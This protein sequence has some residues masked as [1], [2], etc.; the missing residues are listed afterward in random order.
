MRGLTGK[1]LSLIVLL[2]SLSYGSMMAQQQNTKKEKE[3]GSGDE[4]NLSLDSVVVSAWKNRS[5]LQT[6]RGGYEW[7]MGIMHILPKF[8][9]NADPIRH[10]QV[11][12]G[13]QTNGEYAG[14][15]HVEGCDNQHNT[16]SINGVPLYNV[17]HILGFF[18]TFNPTHYTLMSLSK[19]PQDAA[20]DN[21]LGATLDM[22]LSDQLSDT[23]S[24][25]ADVGLI[26]S[27][28]TV[29]LPLGKET[30]LRLSARTSYINLLYSRW[31]RSD[32]EELKYSFYDVNASVLHKFDSKNKILLDFYTGGDNGRVFISDYLSTV[33]EHWGNTAGSLQWLHNG[34]DDFSMRHILYC[35]HYY[36]KLSLDMNAF[37]FRMPSNI[38]DLGYKGKIMWRG[39]TTGLDVIQH[40]LM[41]QHANVI[42]DYHAEVLDP[43]AQWGGEYSLYADY[44]RKLTDRLIFNTGLR[45]TIFHSNFDTYHS[46]A[47]NIGAVYN[48]DKWKISLSYAMRS[49]Y[50]FQTG[51]SSLG[52]P[53]ESWTMAGSDDIIP[54]LGHGFTAS[55]SINIAGGR[56]QL[57]L[58]AYYR[59]LDGQVEYQGTFYDFIVSDY[60]LNKHLLHGRGRNFGVSLMLTKRTGRLTGWMSYSFGRALRT[61]DNKDFD[62]TYPASH[63]RIH[64]L[65]LLASYKLSRRFNLGATFVLASGTPFTAPKY[66]YI[67]NQKIVTQYAD[68]NK[69]RLPAYCRL[70]LSLNCRLGR[71]Q[72]KT[73]KGLNLSLY[74][75]LNHVN[76]LYYG[77]KIYNNK[78]AYKRVNFLM[79]MLPSI[80]FYYKY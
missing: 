50:M 39:L 46:L 60:Q 42:S 65:N 77:M 64:E 4:K 45:Y 74:N 22:Q 6:I 58:D 44:S 37:A 55:S 1:S 62:D 27:Q 67:I 68:H 8:M 12:P 28:G 53:T 79:F 75:A 54:Q 11:L 40:R 43:S 19:S 5:S 30:N 29:C 59:W 52:L 20:A 2:L 14:G 73:E 56:Y 3:T 34:G 36:N 21:R 48:T 24:I 17:S 66:F 57:T 35:T 15:L 78:V 18:S 76:V 80:S 47:P 38:T 72:S 70:D 32:N 26:S 33:K 71:L 16:Y 13:V 23:V 61:F 51:F 7:D 9:G 63:E 31:L 49:Q 10:T 41:P 25:D 69:N